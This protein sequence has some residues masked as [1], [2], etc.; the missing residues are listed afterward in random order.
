MKV[1]LPV[2]EY[3]IFQS[4]LKERKFKQNTNKPTPCDP[5]SDAIM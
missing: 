2:D 1:Y 3:S 4:K 5:L